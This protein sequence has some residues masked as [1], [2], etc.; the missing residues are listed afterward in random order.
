MGK[1][2]NIEAPLVDD[3]PTQDLPESAGAEV[4]LLP[5]V[6]KELLK[7][8][9]ANISLSESRLAMECGYIKLN[10]AGE[11]RGNVLALKNALLSA[12][13]TNLNSVTTIDA[14]PVEPN[15]KGRVYDRGIVS[16]GGKYTTSIGLKAGDEYQIRVVKGK[17]PKLIITPIILEQFDLAQGQYRQDLF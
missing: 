15:Y 4:C 17:K 11:H 5:L 9:K 6:G 13:G 7:K 14:P 8:V 2:L 1:S 10:K 16:I 12:H 3:N